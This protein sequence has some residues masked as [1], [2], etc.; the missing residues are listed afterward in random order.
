VNRR[1]GRHA[2]RAVPPLVALAAIVAVAAPAHAGPPTSTA[3]LSHLTVVFTDPGPPGSGRRPEAAIAAA[4]SGQVA[5][6]AAAGNDP[7]IID[8]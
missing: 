7:P 3:G 6:A 2:R 4:P 1:T 5:V 8:D